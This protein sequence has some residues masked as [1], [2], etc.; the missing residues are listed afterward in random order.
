[1]VNIYQLCF[2]TVELYT[3]VQPWLHVLVIMMVSVS[4]LVHR[5]LLHIHACYN[6]SGSI[7]SPWLHIHV[8]VAGIRAG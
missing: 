3:M 2:I 1:M 5:H 4:E 7:R 8:I 6:D